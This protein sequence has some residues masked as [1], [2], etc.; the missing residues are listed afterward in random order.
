MRPLDVTLRKNKKTC[1]YSQKVRASGSF[2]TTTSTWPSPERQT[3]VQKQKE[4]EQYALSGVC[5]QHR[6]IWLEHIERGVFCSPTTL[7]LLQ[8]A[9]GETNQ[10]HF[11]FTFAFFRMV[12]FLPVFDLV[13]GCANTLRTRNRFCF[14]VPCL[15]TLYFVLDL[16]VFTRSGSES[17]VQL[18]ITLCYS[19]ILISGRISWFWGDPD[20]TLISI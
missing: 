9:P 4:R 6:T 10:L 17:L 15:L 13:T 20:L 8:W 2:H 5:T 7:V 19:R 12:F 18:I 1:F 14:S 16:L 11:F 3:G